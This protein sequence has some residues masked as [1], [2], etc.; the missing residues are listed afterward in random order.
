MMTK[1][2]VISVIA[3]I[4]RNRELGRG[5]QLLWHIRDDLKRFKSLTI[6]HPVIMGRITYESMGKPLPGRVN[7]VITRDKN[8]A[9]EGTVTV[10]SFEEALEEAGKLDQDEIF[11]IG[12]SQIY[13]QALPHTDKL[14][15]T[16]IDDE[17]KA[18]SFF[19]AYEYLFKK[20]TFEE[21]RFDEKTGLHYRWVDLERG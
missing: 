14:Y 12:G 1:S 5:N 21:K 15:L 4:G 11:I 8:L 13:R 17:K 3:A 7:I 10:H 16:L 6:G 18:D 19:P 9:Y 2:P 20:K